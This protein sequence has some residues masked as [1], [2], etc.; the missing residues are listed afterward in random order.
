MKTL[1]LNIFFYCLLPFFAF[2]ENSSWWGEG[3]KA[4][5][6]R[7]VADIETIRIAFDQMYAPAEWKWSYC[8]WNLDREANLAKNKILF[9]DSINTKKY[10][11]IAKEF[12][13]STKDYHVNVS[14]YSTESATL[15]FIIQGSNHRYFFTQSY[16]LNDVYI[17]PGDELILFDNQPVDA[18]IQKLIDKYGYHSTPDTDQTLGEIYLTGR[19]GFL[20]MEVPKGEIPIVVKIKN[21]G[22]EKKIN[23]EWDYRPEKIANHFNLNNDEPFKGKSK[24]QMAQE[25]VRKFCSNTMEFTPATQLLK[26]IEAQNRFDHKSFLPPLGEK[27]W[28]T[29][30]FFYAYI[31]E[32]DGKKIGYV[33]IPDY[34]NNPH[35]EA[36]LEF[37]NII[38][39][40]QDTDALVIDQLDNP[41]GY[42][43]YLYSL[44]S[45]L[46]DT[47]LTVP[48]HRV[49]ISYDHL[50]DGLEF[51]DILEDVSY[52]GDILMTIGTDLY[53]YIV[54]A[55][56][57]DQLKQY[58]EYILKEWKEEHYFTHP[59]HLF[60]IDEIPP[61]ADPKRRYTK[62]ILLL[63]NELDFSGGDFFPAILQDNKRATILGNRTA[64]AGGCVKSFEM[65][66]RFGIERIRY[67]WTL[68]ERA[69][70]DPIENLG[71]TPDIPYAITVK[72][73]QSN[74]EDYMAKIN[75]S[76]MN[77]IEST[78]VPSQKEASTKND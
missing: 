73:L 69:N 54:T 31:Y 56:L 15:P 24:K 74:F 1:F 75:S 62:P 67:T 77:L 46:T 76:V 3:S 12:L 60:G 33:R 38:K 41:G 28:E 52:D 27:I 55:K 7:M 68:A 19:Y 9:S 8:D 43:V 30:Y 17:E 78:E 6:N 11:E 37:G 51:L 35:Y 59:I 4:N 57:A 21:T 22:E 10:Q 39:K 64:G 50:M 23:L 53:G 18:I 34:Y 14:F 2:A 70:L 71:V 40:F 44:L 58:A 49:K 25:K 48:K 13:L 66:N 32:L 36:V 45:M 5:R 47:P 65:I 42:V 72:D 29:N 16:R 20:G 26:N 61:H 63:T